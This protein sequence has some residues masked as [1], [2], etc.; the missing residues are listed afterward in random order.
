MKLKS[1][2][3]AL[4]LAILSCHLF[5]S[6]LIKAQCHIDDWTVLKILYEST[7]GDNWKHNTNWEEIKGNAP[8]VNCNLDDLTRVWLNENGRV[9]KL[10][11][12]GNRLKGSIPPELGNLSNLTSLVLYG[13]QLSGT[14]LD[15][16]EFGR[17]STQ[18]KHPTR[19]RESEKFEKLVFEQKS[20]E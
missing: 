9:K 18:R 20:I 8:T 19:I 3:L 16:I 12:T 2:K 10:D 13:N 6:K 5:D 7:D 17:K 14:I 4:I 11:L 15:R 1:T